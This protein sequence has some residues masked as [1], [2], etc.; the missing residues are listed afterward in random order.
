[1]NYHFKIT[2]ESKGYSAECVELSGCRTQ[3]D[4]FGELKEN[5]KD[6]LN[7]FLSEDKGSELIFKGPIKI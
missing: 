4:F 3:G 7:L 5:M 6:A 2:K 1:M